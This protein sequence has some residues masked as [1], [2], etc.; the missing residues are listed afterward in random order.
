MKNLIFCMCFAAALSCSGGDK[1]PVV[2]FS[3]AGPADASAPPDA[4][5]CALTDCDGLCVDTSS[6]PLN[7]GG[8][9]MACQSAGQ[10]CSGSVPC[11]CPAAFL[12][13]NLGGPIDQVQMQGSLYVAASPLI[14]GTIDVAA[15]IY[16]LTLETGVVYDFADS[17]AGLSPPALAAGYDVN[18]NNFTAHTAYGAFEGTIVFDTICETGVSGTITAPVFSEVLGVTNPTPVVD[19]CTM[20]YETLGFDIG[21]CPEIPPDA[22]V[23]LPD[24]GVPDATPGN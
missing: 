19:G 11:E 24:A 17:V 20:S 1:D 23:A 10:I 13:A 7:C 6:D 12:P 2:T 3:D 16:D 15:V 22:G 4:A 5:P 8:C 9:G 21:S 14:G 18:V